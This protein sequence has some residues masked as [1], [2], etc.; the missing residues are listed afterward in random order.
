MNALE[1]IKLVLKISI[2][3]TALGFGLQAVPRDVFYLFRHP[4]QLLRAFLAMNIIMPVF[5]IVVAL[6]F[7][8]SPLVKV[9]L[10]AISLSPL[11]PVFPK[12]TKQTGEDGSYTI[13][14]MVAAC[15][16]SLVMIP[17]T[18]TLLEKLLDKPVEISMPAILIAVLTTVFAPLLLG[19]AIRYLA[20]ALAEKTAGWVARIA[21]ILLIISVLPILFKMFPAIIHLAG[22]GTI[23]VLVAFVLVGLVVGHLLGGPSPENRSV[24]ALATAARHP[25]IALS[26]ASANLPDHKLLPAA[27]LLYLLINAIVILPYQKWIAKRNDPTSNP[28]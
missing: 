13:G 12:K 24:L 21:Q 6:N 5:A 4:G 8:L 25:A 1:I 18:L 19:I 7:E 16:F 15:L 26:L 2:F 3:L 11:P 22:H 10:I 9:A 20:P 27:I 28:V 14:L 23:L 17:L